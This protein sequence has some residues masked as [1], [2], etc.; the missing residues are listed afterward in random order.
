MWGTPWAGCSGFNKK[1]GWTSNTDKTLP[2]SMFLYKFPA[3]NMV[4]MR[5]RLKCRLYVCLLTSNIQVR[6]MYSELKLNRGP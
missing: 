6:S 4:Q 2:I 5:S 3:E 1:G